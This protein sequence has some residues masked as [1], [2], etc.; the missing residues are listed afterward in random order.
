MLDPS[1]PNGQGVRVTVAGLEALRLTPGACEK[2]KLEAIRRVLSAP[3][4]SVEQTK[5]PDCQT[6]A[7]PSAQAETPVPPFTGARAPLTC[8]VSSTLVCPT[9][10]DADNMIEKKRYVFMAFTFE[11]RVRHPKSVRSRTARSVSP[12]DTGREMP[13]GRL[14][15]GVGAREEEECPRLSKH[16]GHPVHKGNV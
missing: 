3:P 6:K 12:L 4:L 13:A 7:S 10:D 15:A 8:S 2:S 1:T 5:A 11:K 16:K 14:L 9:R